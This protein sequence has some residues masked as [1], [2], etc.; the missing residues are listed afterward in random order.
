VSEPLAHAEA[1]GEGEGEGGAVGG[2][3]REPAG[4]LA[5]PEAV[6]GEEAVVEAEGVGVG[7]GEQVGEGVVEGEVVKVGE[8]ER[9]GER[10]GVAEADCVLLGVCEAGDG[11]GGL[12]GLGALGAVWTWIFTAETRDIPVS[13]AVADTDRKKSWEIA[14]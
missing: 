14:T 3:E 12:R 4:A 1:L 8:G 11:R 13:P 6:G 9:E 10:E 2:A 5:L 7:V